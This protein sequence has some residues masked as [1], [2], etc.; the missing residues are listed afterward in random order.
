MRATWTCSK[1]LQCLNNFFFLE[2]HHISSFVKEETDYPNPSVTLR[3]INE[4][5]VYH[6]LSLSPSP[7]LS[8][9]SSQFVSTLINY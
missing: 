8:L 5:L 9:S 3:E 7:S 1:M 2:D 6:S 4:Q